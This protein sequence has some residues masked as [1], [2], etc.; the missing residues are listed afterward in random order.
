VRTAL[1][2]LAL[3]LLGCHVLFPF[4]E[5]TR[6]DS[7]ADSTV[8]DRGR[9]GTPVAD[10]PCLAVTHS[11]PA[12]LPQPPNSDY[13]DWA[14]FLSAD[15]LALVFS[16]YQTNTKNDIWIATRSRPDEAFSTPVI[17]GSPINTACDEGTPSLSGNGLRLYFASR[18][19]ESGACE[20]CYDIWIATRDS[21]SLPFSAPSR[22]SGLSS[23]ASNESSPRLSADDRTLYF[24][25]DRS[26]SSDIWV[27]ARGPDE[28]FSNVRSLPY[29]NSPELD[30]TPAISADG[31]TL[32][33]ASRRP[34]SQ[35]WDIWV[36]HRAKQEDEFSAPA[37]VPKLQSP[38]DDWCPTLAADGK[39]LLLN[40]NAVL[41]GGTPAPRGDIFSSTITCRPGGG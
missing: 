7:A 40:Y 26:G 3:L 25:S 18:R 37:L 10:G 13:D 20:A 5:G 21:Q 12:R 2:P 6:R 17:L 30:D 22:L 16:V 32:Y 1:P 15:G 33:F 35:R 41:G 38:L 24:T 4:E 39:T 36:A 11:T 29:V 19:N 8:S 27:A 14:P 28:S 23:A 34:P 9:E 31:L